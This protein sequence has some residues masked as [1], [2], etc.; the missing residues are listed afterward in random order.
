MKSNLIKKVL[1]FTAITYVVS[2]VIVFVIL[3]HVSYNY[4]FEHIQDN[5]VNVKALRY[6]VSNHQKSEVYRLQNQN[7]ISKE[8]FKPQ[9]LSSTYSAKTVNEKYNQIRKENGLEPITVRFASDNPRNPKN[10]ADQFESKLLKQF[11]DK[12]ITQYKEVKYN[13]DGKKVIYYAVPTRPLEEKCM[14]CHSTPNKAPK[15]LLEIYGD[16]NGFYEEIGSIR[17]LI[18]TEYPLSKTDAFLYKTIAILAVLSLFVHGIFI[19]MYLDFSKKVIQSNDKLK[20]LNDNL[21]DKIKQE[22]K[23]LS[24]SNK[25][26]KQQKMFLDTLIQ[27]LPIPVFFKDID[28]KYIDV[29]KNFSE[30]TGLHK[31]DVIGKSVYDIAPK[32]LAKMY[33]EQD[34][35]VFSL[36]ENPQVYESKLINKITKQEHDVIFY[37]SAFLDDNNKV[38]G[39]IG[40]VVDIT[41]RKQLEEEKAQNEKR[42]YE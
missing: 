15:G 5:L 16:K 8:Y 35:R 40:T 37:K 25:K 7:N 28:G 9:L 18:S 6:Y 10:K 26:L 2:L 23:T 20:E 22:T 34:R 13:K 32:E 31:D 12:T 42:Y 3:K 19:L 33:D 4:S 30:F 41:K 29:N 11:N 24:Q 27:A 21:E 38:L 1:L 36:E 39:L 14:R 17:A